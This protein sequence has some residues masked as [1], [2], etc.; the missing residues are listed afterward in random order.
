M[1]KTPVPL[2]L[3]SDAPSSGTGLGRI[4]K[5]LATRI[6]AHLPDVCRVATLGYGGAG[7]A[8]LDF[9]Q[10]TIED[11]KDFIVPALPQVWEDFAGDQ[12]GIVMTIW[13]LSRLM[14]LTQPARCEMLADYPVLW[15][16]L[17]NSPPFRRWG[18]FPI[19][20][21]GPNGKLTFPL[22]QTLLGYD[23]VLAYGPWGEGV[24]QQTIGEEESQ[25]PPARSA[26]ARHRYRGLLPARS[27]ALPL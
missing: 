22:H 12:P 18:Y 25:Q 3:I 27:R 15:Q 21:G 20:A 5:D 6:H 7:S 2:L 24:I 9:P 16:W 19:D 13:D 1:I 4:T 11:M 14:W 17:V 8:K 26:S 10:Y 23:R